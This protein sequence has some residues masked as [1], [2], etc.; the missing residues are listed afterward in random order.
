M[1]VTVLRLL[2]A[3]E[4]LRH[5]VPA[6]RS[7]VAVQEAMALVLV[8]AEGEEQRVIVVLVG[9]AAY[10]QVLMMVPQVQE[11]EVEVLVPLIPH[12]KVRRVVVASVCWVPVL[13]AQVV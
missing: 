8:V 9:K 10:L 11:E 13:T 1:E 2:E 5:Q 3:Q 7:K 12:S 6:I 4:E